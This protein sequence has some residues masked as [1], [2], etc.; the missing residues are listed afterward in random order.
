M[1][2]TEALVKTIVEGLQEKKGKNIVTVDLTQLSGSI[3]QYIESGF[4]PALRWAK[5]Q[6]E[7]D[8]AETWVG[9]LPSQI[10]IYWQI[11]L[12][13]WVKSTVT[14]FLPFFSC[15]PSTIVLTNASV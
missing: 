3:C 1:D 13:N 9:V 7:S 15:R 11:E 5:S 8:N 4:S 12:D 14:M 2:Q 6:A 10:I